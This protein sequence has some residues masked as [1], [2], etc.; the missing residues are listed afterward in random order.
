MR[1]VFGRHLSCIDAF[2]NLRPEMAIES[3][4]EIP[5]EFIDSEIPLLLIGAM[6]ADAVG[7]EKDLHWFVGVKRPRDGDA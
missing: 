7:F 1:L 3:L 5:G 4:R 6:T 2:D